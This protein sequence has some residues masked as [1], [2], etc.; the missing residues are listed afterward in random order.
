MYSEGTDLTSSDFEAL[1]RELHKLGI[2]IG[3]QTT[4]HGI[5]VWVADSVGR[6]RHDF[7]IEADSATGAWPSV[8]AT[9]WARTT[10]LQ[11]FPT[12]FNGHGLS[13]T[14]LQPAALKRR[15]RQRAALPVSQTVSDEQP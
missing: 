9:Q 1:A 3:M 4:Q 13:A 7:T 8:A 15:G 2:Y 10:A 11:M 14:P 5:L 12:K 6:Y